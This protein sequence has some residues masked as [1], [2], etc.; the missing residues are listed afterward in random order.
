MKTGHWRVSAVIL[1]LGAAGLLVST[2]EDAGTSGSHGFVSSAHAQPLRKLIARWRGKTLPDGIDKAEGRIEATQVDVSSK[3]PGQLAEL[4]VEEGTKVAIGQVIGRVTSPEFEAQLR[5]AQSVLQAAQDGLAGAESEIA[6][7]RSALEFA[8]S[9]F[10]RGQELMKSGFIT[11]QAFEER[12]RNYDSA[13][14]AVQNM[15]ARRDQAQSAIKAAEAKVQ[16]IEFDDPRS[17]ARVPAQRKSSV[18]DGAK[19]RNRGGR[20]TARD[21]S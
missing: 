16:E 2:A 5:A 19:R 17:H 8:K 1:L 7:R 4:S 18:S 10:E 9:D 14:A 13:Q 12:R 15:T 20:R 3:Y 21:N 11:K 6:S